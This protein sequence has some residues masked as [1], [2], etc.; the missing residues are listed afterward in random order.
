[1]ICAGSAGRAHLTTAEAACQPAQC[2]VCSHDCD[3]AGTVASAG[4]LTAWQ[5]TPSISAGACLR[6]RSNANGQPGL[7]AQ[8]GGG[9][10]GLGVSPFTG[11]RW[12][13]DIAKSGTA[14]S[15]IFV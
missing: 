1:M 12:P 13:P 15:S 11:I 10:I 2:A 3:H 14:P 9:S 7:N 8:P 6:Q 4:L 5:A